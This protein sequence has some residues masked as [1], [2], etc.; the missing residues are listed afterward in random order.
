MMALTPRLACPRFTRNSRI[1]EVYAHLTHPPL[2]PAQARRVGGRTGGPFPG[3]DKPGAA[4]SA[5]TSAPPRGVGRAPAAPPQ[6]GKAQH[7]LQRPGA[8]AERAVAAGQR[9]RLGGNWDP[10]VGGCWGWGENSDPG[11]GILGGGGG[12]V[13]KVAEPL[14]LSPGRRESR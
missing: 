6:P 13:G 2:M 1:N 12:C 5:P 10:E 4:C 8:R 14:R 7:R 9:G 3:G 11:R